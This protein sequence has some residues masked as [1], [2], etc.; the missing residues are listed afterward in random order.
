[1]E[2]RTEDGYVYFLTFGILARFPVLMLEPPRME[3]INT[4]QFVNV[5]SQE[6][7][8]GHMDAPVSFQS[9]HELEREL[10][11][12]RREF[13]M[14]QR[15]ELH[16]FPLIRFFH[17]I[18]AFT[19]PSGVSTDGFISAGRADQAITVFVIEV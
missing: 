5:F 15:S 11:L 10:I 14:I 12:G 3:E 13:Y 19:N 1:M 7:N 17:T 9:V 6:L 4:G 2:V 16:S 18:H 8:S